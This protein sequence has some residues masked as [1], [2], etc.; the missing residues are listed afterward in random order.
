M[1]DYPSPVP[2][3]RRIVQ[4]IVTALSLILSVVLIIVLATAEPDSSV[5]QRGFDSGHASG[6]VDGK[7]E[8]AAPAYKRGYDAGETAGRKSGRTAGYN[9]GYVDG[10][11]YMQDQVDELERQLRGYKKK[12]TGQDAVEEWLEIN[13]ASYIGNSETG[14]FHRLDC[15]YLP[16]NWN[17]VYFETADEA[18]A[19]GYS[20]CG[21]CNP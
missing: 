4:N 18:R 16:E 11:R 17:R 7:N 12:L 8:G 6:Y 14:K 5:Y 13:S 15:S 3:R 9:S 20:P 1:S 2:K 10:M 21:H 19:A